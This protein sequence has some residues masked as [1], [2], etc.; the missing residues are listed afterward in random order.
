MIE[1]INEFLSTAGLGDIHGNLIEKMFFIDN[2]F[3]ML[4]T[5]IA[6]PVITIGI[7]RHRQYK[8]WLKNRA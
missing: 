8:K 2:V 4:V 7:I 3:V 1:R 6:I 5:I